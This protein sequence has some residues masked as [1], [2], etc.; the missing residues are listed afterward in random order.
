VPEGA[1]PEDAKT[2]R[3]WRVLR[4]VQ[5]HDLELTGEPP[6]AEDYFGGMTITLD[7]PVGRARPEGKLRV[8]DRWLDHVDVYEMTL[9]E[10]HS[11]VL[12]HA[13]RSAYAAAFP[14][15]GCF[16]CGRLD[17]RWRTRLGRS[18]P[19]RPNHTRTKGK[20]SDESY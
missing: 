7:N 1:E 2:D 13:K 20:A 17:L 12:W 18:N 5:A 8:V 16:I 4:V 11:S 15:A 6:P 9:E 3:G 14:D 10:Y 19:I